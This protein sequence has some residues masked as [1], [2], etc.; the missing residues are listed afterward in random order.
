MNFEIDKKIKELRIKKKMSIQSLSDI[1]GVSTGQ[2]SQIERGKV[3]PSVVCLWKIAE[4]LGVSMNYF[5][6][7]EKKDCVVQHQGQRK[8]IIVN[9]GM[10]TYEILSPNG[11]DHLIDFVKITL[12]GHG[13]YNPM[14]GITH[15]GEEGGYVLSGSM[16]VHVNEEDF[17]LNEGDSIYF[18]STLPHYYINT[19]DEDCVSIWAMTPL[20]F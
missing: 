6:G 7:D 16:I 3:T 10:N 17:L 9:E 13:T 1:S 20:F 15:Q 5:F 11:K 14:N 19:G 4:G 18:Q 12:K 2:I 8:K